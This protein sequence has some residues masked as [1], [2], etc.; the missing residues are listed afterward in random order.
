MR[1]LPV[2]VIGILLAVLP[3]SEC[4][5]R[6]YQLAKGERPVRIVYLHQYFATPDQGGGTR[7]YEFARRWVRAGYE[8]HVLRVGAPAGSSSRG[9]A[10]TEVEGISVHTLALAY[11]N[12]MG[13]Y[14]RLAA[15]AGYAASAAGRARRLRPDAIYATS[16]PLTVAVPALA[17]SSAGGAPYVF[18]VRDLWPD[19]PIALGYLKNPILRKA[20]VSLEKLAYKRSAHIVALA[21]GM[22]DDIVTKGVPP[23][24]ISVIPQ[25]CDSYMFRSANPGQVHAD[26]PWL[27]AG[28]V[29]TYAGAIGQANGLRYL[30]DVATAMEDIDRD[31]R[32]VVIGE[33]RERKHLE[34]LASERG[35][36]GRSIFFLGALSKHE[37][38]DW[39]AASDATLAFLTGP[40]VLWKDAV[41]NKF[42][43]SL[44]AERPIA[45]NN[46]GWQTQVA[47][48]AGVGVMLNAEDPSVGA[49][50]LAAMVGNAEFM[51]RVP[52]KC[53]ELAATKFNRDL[54]AEEA[55]QVLVLAAEPVKGMA[56]RPDALPGRSL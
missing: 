29:F 31:A 28:P 18:E 47:V 52:Q 37:V 11:S 22:K 16:T 55:L 41:Q 19:V 12:K 53:R 7:S 54:Q 21:P 38:A 10:V 33:G 1:D 43:D 20:A 49:G 5:A 45:T 51:A 56:S 14:R 23:S 6:F 24:K 27:G 50:Q 35:L 13:F 39:M 30:I 9:W 42:F 34:E 3:L 17:A 44:A 46:D 48:D 32:F 15:F 40:R 26:N 8:V 36:L 2:R 4:W 25:G